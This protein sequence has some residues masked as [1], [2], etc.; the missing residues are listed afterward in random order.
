MKILVTGATGNF[1]TAAIESLLK[2]GTDKNSI[3]ALVRDETKAAELKALGITIKTG[4]YDNHASL[5]AAFKDVDKLLF[6][7]SSEIENRSEQQV[8]VVK[9]AKEAGVKHII[10]TSLERKTDSENTSLSFVLNSHIATENAIKESGMNYTFLRNNLYLDILPFFLG[11][12]VSETGIFLPAAD[13]K[14]GFTLRSEM[15]EIAANVLTSDGHE[16][17]HYH[18]SATE[19]VSFGDV[20]AM[21]T[22]ITGKEISYH[23]PDYQNYVSTMQAAGAPDEFTFMLGGF[24]EAARH[25]ELAGGFSEAEKLLNRKLTTVKDFLT[26]KYS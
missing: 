11:E 7:S 19:P 10:Y 24:S 20:A 5:L 23:S 3:T 2:K 25:G 16:N 15:A 26:Q 12:K 9:A 14:I 4:N 8:G 17:K 18:I 22:G 6:I 21:L 1:G 13:G